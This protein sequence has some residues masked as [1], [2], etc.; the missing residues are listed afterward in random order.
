M[1]DFVTFFWHYS[2]ENEFVISRV[3]SIYPFLISQSDV[4][5]DI[6]PVSSATVM[7]NPL[8]VNKLRCENAV[9]SAILNFVR[10]LLSCKFLIFT[11]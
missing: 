4:S 7:P 3:S 5:H 8:Q 6:L 2:I 9:L 11:K 10:F 1:T